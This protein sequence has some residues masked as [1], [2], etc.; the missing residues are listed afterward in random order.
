MAGGGLCTPWLLTRTYDDK[1]R[2]FSGR[3]EMTPS[4][5]REMHHPQ[6]RHTPS[7]IAMV[8]PGWPADCFPNGIVTYTTTLRSG[9]RRAGA[10]V[11]VL[12]DQLRSESRQD[13]VVALIR[14]YRPAELVS[15]VAWRLPGW[16]IRRS[17][18]VRNNATR[19]KRSVRLLHR[20]M[21]LQL[22][23]MEE[24]F[25][26]TGHLVGKCPVPL[27]VRL[28]GPHFLTSVFGSGLHPDGLHRWQNRSEG[29]GIRAATGV[30]APSEDV[31]ERTREFYGLELPTSAVIPNPIEPVS[32]PKRWSPNQCEEETILFVGRFDRLK[33]A[34]VVIKAFGRVAACRPKSRLIF[35]GP[36]RGLLDESG[37]HWQVESYA[38]A[39]LPPDSLARF[40]YLGFRSGDELEQLRRE[41]A[42]VVVP[43]R[44]E[45]FPYT[46]L[47][48]CALGCPLITSDIGGLSEIIKDGETG[49]LAE[50][51]DPDDL[52]MKI[53]KLLDHRE[54]A[55]RLGESAARDAE[56]RFHP[57]VIAR[58]TLEFYGRVI[59]QHRDETHR[60]R[61]R[62]R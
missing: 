37:L 24:T 12:T 25:G 13:D 31:L 27:V 1:E 32:R 30:S 18:S 14:G 7:A 20:R 4:V 2:Q 23:E 61:R 39:H 52:A 5:S 22:L 54:L 58:R 21:G 44:Y 9:L 49:L 57:D 19:I 62:W 15:H 41:A 46:A 60:R 40:E 56:R 3:P 53:T 8:T 11:F 6:I 28:H 36:D 47:E 50:P 35:V 33:G 55:A 43:S 59:E 38:R 26:I 34:D 29:A 45:N 16:R 17:L 48:A 51:G 10:R 42:V